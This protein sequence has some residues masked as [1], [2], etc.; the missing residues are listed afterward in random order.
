VQ[1]IF[2]NAMVIN[3]SIEVYLLDTAGRI[4]TYHTPGDSLLRKK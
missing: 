4:L 2:F 3:P 1:R